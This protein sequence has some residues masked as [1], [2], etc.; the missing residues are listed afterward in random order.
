MIP[1]FRKRHNAIARRR[2]SATIAMRTRIGRL[3][4]FLVTESN[5]GNWPN[6]ALR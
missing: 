4:D 5:D 1:S 3:K 6:S 2:A